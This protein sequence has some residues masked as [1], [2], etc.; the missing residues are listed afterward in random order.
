MKIFNSKHWTYGAGHFYIYNVYGAVFPRL[1][2]FTICSQFVHDLF[3]IGVV[4]SA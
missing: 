2:M 3:I 1:E 4:Q